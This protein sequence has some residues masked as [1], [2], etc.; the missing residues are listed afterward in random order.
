MGWGFVEGK[1][2]RGTTFE[3]QI[4]KI[5]NKTNK[6]TNKTTNQRNKQKLTRANSLHFNTDNEF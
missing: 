4:N 3:I 6:Q 2:G 1:L 5:T